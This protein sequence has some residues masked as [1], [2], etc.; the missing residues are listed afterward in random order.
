MILTSL[1]I[2]NF[3]LFLNKKIEFEPGLNIITGLNASGKTTVLESIYYLSV[4]K[5]FR[6]VQDYDLISLNCE[7]MSVIGEVETKKGRKKVRTSRSFR[8]KSV[9]RNETKCRKISDYLGE[10]LTVAFSN[11]DLFGL[12]GSPKDRRKIFEPIICQI[13]NFYVDE[14]NR[15][16]KILNERNALLKRLIFENSKALSDLLCIVTNQLVDS[17]KKI[18]SIRVDFVNK[19]N[20]KLNTIHNKICGCYEDVCVKYLPSVE[21]DRMLETLEQNVGADIKKGSTSYGPHRDDFGFYINGKNVVTQG[22]QGQQRNILITVK[23]AFVD[24]IKKIKEE[25]AILLLD[26]VFSELDKVRQNNL[27]QVINCETQTII[28]TATLAE[29]DNKLLEKAN[30]ITL[31]KEEKENG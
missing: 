13:S 20:E 3:R 23:I 26:D 15:Y 4:T 16:K 12:V 14:C 28:S 1:K 30:I 10:V 27:L 5:S 8:G 6:E 7:E 29:I 25:E 9:Y 24:I 22:S 17:A 11:S 21:G 19:L 31:K 2:Y 18:I